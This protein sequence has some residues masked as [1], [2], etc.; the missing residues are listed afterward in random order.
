VRWAASIVF[1]DTTLF[2]LPHTK[3]IDELTRRHY[4]VTPCQKANNQ[5]LLCT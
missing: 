3:R 1:S 2:R 5:S 4:N